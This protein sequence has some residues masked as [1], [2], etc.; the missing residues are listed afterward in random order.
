MIKAI[1]MNE[2]GFSVEDFEACEVVKELEAKKFASYMEA[3][4]EMKTEYE[5]SLYE[6][7]VKAE[8]LESPDAD[9]WENMIYA[10]DP[11]GVYDGERNI[12]RNVTSM[13][14]GAATEEEIDFVDALDAT[15]KSLM[16]MVG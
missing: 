6:Y 14:R 2:K 3:V 15:Y 9:T 4:N 8:G 10:G 13:D 16:A 7:L 11:K 1:V 12:Y 5:E